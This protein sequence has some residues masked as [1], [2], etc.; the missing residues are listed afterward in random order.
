MV[1]LN[2]FLAYI[3]SAV[4]SQKHRTLMKRLCFLVQKPLSHSNAT[5]V[6]TA[7]FGIHD[8]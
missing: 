6:S 4:Q 5:K 3:M 2:Q 1:K 7:Q 8:T